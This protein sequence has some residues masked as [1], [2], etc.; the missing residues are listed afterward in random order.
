MDS[1]PEAESEG[2]MF[3][4]AWQFFLIPTDPAP[5]IWQ[6]GWCAPLRVSWTWGGGA[7]AGLFCLCLWCRQLQQHGRHLPYRSPK[8]WL[9]GPS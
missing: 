8:P 2:I 1:E 5:L 7:L 3:S 6:F 4:K 9:P